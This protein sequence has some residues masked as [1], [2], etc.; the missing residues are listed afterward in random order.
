MEK[1]REVRDYIDL[2][3]ALR[4]RAAE[5]NISRLCIDEVSGLQHGY[6]AKLLSVPPIKCLGRTSLGPLL[7]ALGL[8]LIVAEDPEALAKV[9]R[10]L[11]PKGRGDTRS[12]SINKIADA[13]LRKTM[14]E[15][16]RRG[17][18]ARNQ[19]LTPDQRKAAARHAINA[20]WAKKRQG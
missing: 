9:S 11:V 3:L 2:Q 18:L 7:Q 10:R 17:A 6:S 13:R 14:A 19:A 1:G 12:A 15:N 8:K 16:A 20:R 4:D 5:L